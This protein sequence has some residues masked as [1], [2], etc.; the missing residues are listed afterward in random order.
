MYILY[1]ISIFNEIQLTSI[2]IYMLIV[3][4]K[5]RKINSIFMIIK[6]TLTYL[7]NNYLLG[8]FKNGNYEGEMVS[9]HNWPNAKM[10]KAN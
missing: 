5:S 2:V 3:G 10:L 4:M 6:T 8:H 1:F 7:L 9:T